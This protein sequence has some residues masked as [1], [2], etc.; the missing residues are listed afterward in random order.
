MEPYVILSSLSLSLIFCIVHPCVPPPIEA[1][2]SAALPPPRVAEV[3]GGAARPPPASQGGA[4]ASGGEGRATRPPPASRGSA[5]SSS[6][7][8]AEGGAA[9][10]DGDEDESGA[11]RHRAA[12]VEAATAATGAAAEGLVRPNSAGELRQQE[13]RWQRGWCGPIRTAVELVGDRNRGG[14]PES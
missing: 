14:G 4:V 13:R 2:R 11:A 3:E 6:H 7:G 9:R 5:A 1:G 8:Q 12:G 10:A